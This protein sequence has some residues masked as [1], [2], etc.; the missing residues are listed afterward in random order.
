MR[1]VFLWWWN[2][3]LQL[4]LFKDRRRL[5]HR[6]EHF[7]IRSLLVECVSILMLICIEQ[8]RSERN[9]AICYLFWFCVN[10]VSCCRDLSWNSHEVNKSHVCGVEYFPPA[11][12]FH[13]HIWY[14]TQLVWMNV[15]EPILRK[16]TSDPFFPNP[17]SHFGHGPLPLQWAEIPSITHIKMTGLL[18]RHKSAVQYLLGCFVSKGP[19]R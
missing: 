2:I 10:C 1:R 4:Y 16:I 3:F 13:R 18:D 8:M 19:Q 11:L 7:K 12:S 17:L 15:H 5:K 9:I 14:L 6:W